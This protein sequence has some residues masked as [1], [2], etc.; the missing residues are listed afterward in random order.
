LALAHDISDGFGRT[1]YLIGTP[2]VHRRMTAGRATDKTQLATYLNVETSD[3]SEFHWSHYK[4]C[5][6]RV[7]L[8]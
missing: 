8:C 1:N 5:A 6:W 3:R 2:G 4:L 7:L